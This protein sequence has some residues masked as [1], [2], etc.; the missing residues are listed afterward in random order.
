VR[1][2]GKVEMTPLVQTQSGRK[3]VP[4]GIALPMAWP[5]IKVVVQY[6]MRK[7]KKAVFKCPGRKL[8]IELTFEGQTSR[9][10]PQSF[11]R[12]RFLAQS[13]NNRHLLQ[14]V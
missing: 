8:A 12:F 4:F 10:I 14:F 9:N 1:D 2:S 13:I 11:K 5:P 3:R 7:M 6:Q